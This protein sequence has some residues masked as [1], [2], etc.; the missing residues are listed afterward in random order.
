MVMLTF[1]LVLS[2]SKMNNAANVINIRM[3]YMPTALFVCICKAK[4]DKA[5]ASKEKKYK[6]AFLKYAICIFFSQSNQ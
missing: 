1:V 5:I 2:K 3:L 6:K 4:H